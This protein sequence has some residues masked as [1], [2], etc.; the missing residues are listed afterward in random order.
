MMLRASSIIG[1]YA[2]HLSP[3]DLAAVAAATPGL[4]GR[5]LK[6][7]SEQAE[8]RWASKVWHAYMLQ[9]VGLIVQQT[10][11]YSI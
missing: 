8:R 1:M 2:Q 6:D 11:G 4:A 9:H 5:D 3:E 7:L 10:I